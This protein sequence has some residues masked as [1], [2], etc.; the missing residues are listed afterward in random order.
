[1]VRLPAL[2]DRRLRLE[3][4]DVVLRGLSESVVL[5]AVTCTSSASDRALL[6]QRWGEV[7]SFCESEYDS[8]SLSTEVP[9]RLGWRLEDSWSSEAVAPSLPPG[10]TK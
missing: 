10:C 1:M 2:Q 9:A 6:L 8:L 4:I 7:G 3:P 5:A